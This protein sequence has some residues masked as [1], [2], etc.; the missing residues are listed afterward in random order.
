MAVVGAMRNAGEEG[1]D[2]PRNLTDA[3]R[4]VVDPRLAGEGLLVVMDGAIL[5]ADDVTKTHSTALD[6]FQALNHGPLAHIDRDE[7]VIDR[8]RTRRRTLQPVPTQ[9]AEPVVLLTAV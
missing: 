7:L 5:P 8:R 2:G 4:T 9:A 1:Y 3:V 6:T